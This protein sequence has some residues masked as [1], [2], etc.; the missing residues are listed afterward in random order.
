MKY[1][2]KILAGAA[3]ILL[4]SFAAEVQAQHLVRLTEDEMKNLLGRIEKGSERFRGSL[5]DGLERS[6]FDDSD[7]EDNINRFVKDFE[8][9]TERL[10]NNFDKDHSAS[11]DVQE[12]LERAA[13]IDAFMTHHPLT[14]RAQSDWRD[15][16]GNLDQLARAYQVSWDWGGLSNPPRRINYEEVKLVVARIEKGSDS[17]RG[18]IKRAL[19]KSRFDDT[20]AEDRINGYIREFEAATDRLKSRFDDDQSAAASVEE[21]LSR[22]VMIDRFMQ[23]YGDRL[24]VEANRDW[25]YLRGNLSEL[26]QAYRV[27]WTR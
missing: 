13:R 5:K 2:T 23:D 4:T 12:V 22:A 16:R 25:E 19:E 27:R 20:S 8:A 17:F 21:V 26:A 10:K 1:I 11:A 15:L 14:P 18:S 3:I 6:R 24:T 7:A 9:A